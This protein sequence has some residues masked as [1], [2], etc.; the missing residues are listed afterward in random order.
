V[1]EREEHHPLRMLKDGTR[2]Q[3]DLRDTL[4][5]DKI[6]LGTTALKYERDTGAV[7]ID[8]PETLHAG[9]VYSIDFYYSGHPEE[10]GRFGG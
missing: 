9:Q 7:F 4:N 2:I 3:I 5:I 10:T 8:F 6:L 1:G